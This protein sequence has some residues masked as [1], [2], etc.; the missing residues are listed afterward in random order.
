MRRWARPAK[1]EEALGTRITAWPSNMAD[2]VGGV[3]ILAVPASEADMSKLQPTID[4]E[5]S[6]LT[7]GSRYSFEYR[8]RISLLASLL[9]LEVLLA[10]QRCSPDWR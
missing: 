4:M 7:K 9:C 5:T 6:M 3:E 1:E 10:D 2:M 8:H